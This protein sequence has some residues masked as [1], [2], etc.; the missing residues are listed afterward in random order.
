MCP[1]ASNELW[2]LSDRS[3]RTALLK[4]SKELFPITSTLSINKN[5]F[6][7]MIAGVIVMAQ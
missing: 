1:L 6:D 5:I 7:Q 3:I 4:S 2:Q